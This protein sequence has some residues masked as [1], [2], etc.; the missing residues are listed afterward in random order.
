[1]CAGVIGGAVGGGGYGGVVEV[2]LVVGA[3]VVVEGRDLEDGGRV[4]G[5][6]PGEGDDGVGFAL[7]VAETAGVELLVAGAVGVGVVGDLEV[8]WRSWV[9]RRNWSLGVRL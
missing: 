9:M 1:M 6:E 7:A 4:E 2:G 3:V 5:M 8:V